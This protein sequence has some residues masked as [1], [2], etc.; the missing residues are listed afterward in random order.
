[1]DRFW[2]VATKASSQSASAFLTPS[3]SCHDGEETDVESAAAQPDTAAIL[4]TCESGLLPPLQDSKSDSSKPSQAT[5]NPTPKKDLWYVKGG[6]FAMLATCQFPLTAAKLLETRMV[7][8]GNGNRKPE[9]R[10]AVAIIDKPYQNVYA[11][12]MQLYNPLSSELIISVT[13]PTPKMATQEVH[14]LD[15]WK[16]QVWKLK[17]L[18]KPVQSSI[19]GRYDPNQDPTRIRG[20]I[21]GLLTG[22]SATIQLVTGISIVP[23]DPKMAEDLINK[24]NITQD[25]VTSVYEENKPNWP[26]F[27]GVLVNQ[28]KG[29]LPSK[30]QLGWDTFAAKWKSIGDET[31]TKAVDIWTKR[32]RFDKF[33]VDIDQKDPALQGKFKPIRGVAPKKLLKKFKQLIPA[34]PLVSAGKEQPVW[35]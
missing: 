19:W 17:P 5:S 10:C 13:A 23:P 33:S 7:D 31:T 15:L 11:K 34:L 28:D 3:S 21:E 30:N 32:L 1:M 2:K 27:I 20:P 6:K 35:L 22:D 29:W 4:P 18:I 9:L 8:D 12:P 26:L 14:T 24:F 16:T 25:H